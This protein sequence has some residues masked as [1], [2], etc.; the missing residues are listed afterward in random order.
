MMNQ[1]RHASP[2]THTITARMGTTDPIQALR[3]AA[4]QM[5]V[6]AA[7]VKYESARLGADVARWRRESGTH[8]AIAR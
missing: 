2:R 6:A 7:K 3:N 1:A 5:C 4:N 8:S